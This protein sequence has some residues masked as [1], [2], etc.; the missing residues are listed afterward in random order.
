MFYVLPVLWTGKYTHALVNVAL[1]CFI[2]LFWHL[3]LFAALF[4][5]NDV[6]GIFQ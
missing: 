4:F 5:Q 1:L 6:N 3:S 2:I